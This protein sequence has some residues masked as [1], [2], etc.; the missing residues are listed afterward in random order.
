[1]T[2]F[3]DLTTVFALGGAL[4]FA[5]SL[6]IQKIGLKYAD[7]R[8]GSAINIA[9]ATVLCWMAA[10]YLL[11]TEYF[12][13]TAFFIFA[14]VGVLRPAVSGSLAPAVVKHRGPSMTSAY[15]L[16]RSIAPTLTTSRLTL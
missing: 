16:R 9:A 5:I 8:F 11:N 4:S 12:F 15:M 2:G 3:G 6:H 14:G 1:M 7:P 10:P 13:T